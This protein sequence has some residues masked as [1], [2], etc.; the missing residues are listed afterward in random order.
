MINVTIENFESEVVAASASIPVLVDFW[1]P[2]CGPCKVIGP[3]LEKVETEYEGRFK[4]V[5]IDS[6]E[7]QE[8]AQAFSIR[9]I[10]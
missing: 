6:D 9:S 5:K 4:L 2:W 7:Q 3:I 1:A 8:L 10:R